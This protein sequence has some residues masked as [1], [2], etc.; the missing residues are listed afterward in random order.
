[1]FQ[2]QNGLIKMEKMEIEYFKLSKFQF[3]NGLIK[4]KRG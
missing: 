3:Q 1:M 2:F 4:I